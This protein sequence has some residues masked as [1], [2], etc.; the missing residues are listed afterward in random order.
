[1]GQRR[2][3]RSAARTSRA[4]IEILE[5]RRLLSS[6]GTLDPAFGNGAA[7]VG[8]YVLADAGI[9]P[10]GNQGL[11]R[12]DGRIVLTHKGGYEHVLTALGPS[13]MPDP[14]FNAGQPVTV[15]GQFYD[16][17]ITGIY[18]S[19]N[20]SLLV[21]FDV[22]EYAWAPHQMLKLFTADGDVVTSFGDGGQ[23]VFEFEIGDIAA[24]VHNTPTIPA[25]F[26]ISMRLEP[27]LGLKVATS[28]ST[29][30][31]NPFTL[32]AL[33]LTAASALAATTR[34]RRCKASPSATT[35]T[36]ASAPSLTRT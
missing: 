28:S 15:P 34:R 22:L 33:K 21:S 3:V 31:S 7:G 23:Y 9:E 17:T 10:L 5:S 26:W 19:A 32:P 18:E 11:V 12:D 2:A 8:T 4:S 16:E 29:G 6:D 30:T 35:T 27:T 36:R 14:T 13:G 24:Q 1:M 25:T 20:G